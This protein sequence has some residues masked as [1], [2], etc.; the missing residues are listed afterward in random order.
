MRDRFITATKKVVEDHNQCEAAK[1]GTVPPSSSSAPPPTAQTS[2]SA[3]ATEVAPEESERATEEVVPE[4]TAKATA[5][6]VPEEIEPSSSTAAAP[7]IPS[8]VKNITLPS[9]S[10]VKKT[11]AAEK[12]AKKRKASAPLTITA[13]VKKVKTTPMSSD[14]PIDAIP[15]SSAPPA[16]TD[17]DLQIVPYGVDYE[18]PQADEDDAETHSAA[19]TEQVD[20]E[21]EVEEDASLHQ[22]LSRKPS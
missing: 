8:S 13:T 14:V 15:I 9:A 2:E 17:D 11:K 18:I 6:V 3:R 4:E 21:I 20:E 7:S 12:E 19:T 5:S 10:E 22:V 1:F 16:P